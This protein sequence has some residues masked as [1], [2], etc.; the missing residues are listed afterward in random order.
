ME[1]KRAFQT[2]TPQY[3]KLNKQTN[4]YES[5]IYTLT[6]WRAAAE[7]NMFV[8]GQNAPCVEWSHPDSEVKTHMR[9]N[10]KGCIVMDFATKQTPDIYHNLA[11]MGVCLKLQ[12][13]PMHFYNDKYDTYRF[14]QAQKFKHSV[15]RDK[16]LAVAMIKAMAGVMA[17]APVPQNT[18]AKF[19]CIFPNLHIHM[20]WAHGGMTSVHIQMKERHA[21]EMVDAICQVNRGG[22][23]SY[24]AT[25]YGMD[26]FWTFV[27]RCSKEEN[28]V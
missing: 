10:F 11:S 19:R 7:C 15:H 2:L 16:T 14:F 5:F 4:W 27:H 17:S 12:G 13:N 3:Y 23:V 1:F 26:V 24:N 22:T 25:S 20:E 9:I 28:K 21:L 18:T 6:L 8:K